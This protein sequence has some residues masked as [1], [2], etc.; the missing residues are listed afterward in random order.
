MRAAHV[1]AQF[2][3]TKAGARTPATPARRSWSVREPS[4]LNEGRGTH[5]GDTSGRAQVP[6]RFR[7]SS[8][9]QRRPGHAPRRHATTLRPASIFRIAQRRPGHAPRRHAPDVPD[10]HPTQGARST[11]A[12]ARTP[13]TPGLPGAPYAGS[14]ALNEGRGTHPGDTWRRPGPFGRLRRPLNEGRGT[15]PGDT[16]SSIAIAS[17][18]ILAQRRP[19]HAPRRHVYYKFSGFQVFG[20]QRRPGHAPRRHPVVPRIIR[21]RGGAL[22]EG[23]GTHPGDTPPPGGETQRLCVAQRRP[24]HAPRRHSRSVT[25]TTTRCGAQRRPGHAPR[26]HPPGGAGR[27]ADRGRSTKAG[28]RTPATLRWRPRTM[29]RSWFAQRRPGHAPRRHR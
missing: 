20:A 7:R 9:A 8:D 2:R 16:H 5:P 15:H 4:A 24:G 11:K 27:S 18:P 12:G 23:R 14:F 17:T 26:R 1:G 3:S 21:D 10:V 19:G 22:N 25:L 6:R 28:A 29:C 13:A